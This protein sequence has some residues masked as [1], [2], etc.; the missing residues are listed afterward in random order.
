MCVQDPIAFYRWHGANDSISSHERN[1]NESLFWIE[2][3]RLKPIFSSNASFAKRT[4]STNYM[5]GLYMKEKGEVKGAIN[6]LIKVRNVKSK[7][8][9]LFYILLPK[10]YLYYK[11][12]H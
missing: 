11:R 12:S 3:N 8:K 4:D 7:L 5:N 6:C 9:L 1:V 10:K 2:N